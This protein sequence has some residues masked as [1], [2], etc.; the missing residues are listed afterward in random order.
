[1]TSLPNIFAKGFLS[2]HVRRKLSE[3]NCKTLCGAAVA[4]A[5]GTPFAR[6]LG[7]PVP[8]SSP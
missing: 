5:Q 3:S 8:A 2:A 4:Q 6:H 1:M 7:S